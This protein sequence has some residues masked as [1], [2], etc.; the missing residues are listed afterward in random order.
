MWVATVDLPHAPRITKLF[1][2]SRLPLEALSS[3]DVHKPFLTFVVDLALI[4]WRMG[5]ALE[6]CAEA[7]GAMGS[8]CL[9]CF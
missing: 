9:V 2:S 7:E 5:N 4:G 8:M 6:N 3:S 1:S